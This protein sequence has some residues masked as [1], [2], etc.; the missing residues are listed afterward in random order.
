MVRSHA[1]EVNSHHV[2]QLISNV[3]NAQPLHS[4]TMLLSVSFST[5]SHY[6]Q[7]IYQTVLAMYL[8]RERSSYWLKH[9]MIW[10][11]E[12]LSNNEESSTDETS[13]EDII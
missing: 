8:V 3:F 6:S 5:I 9:S 13:E 4:D 12:T 11:M 10:K 7:S 1:R 2:L